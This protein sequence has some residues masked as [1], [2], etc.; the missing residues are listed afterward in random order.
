MNTNQKTLKLVKMALIVA[1]YVAVTGVFAPI[2]FGNIQFRIS[3]ILVLLIFVDGLYLV[4]LTLGCA[5]S[6]FLFSTMGLVDVICGTGATFLALVMIYLTKQFM[7]KRDVKNITL[8]LFASS[9]WA[10]IVNGVIVGAELYYVLQL[11]FWLSVI[12]VAAGEFVVVSIVGVMVFKYIL[13]NERL[14]D[15][16]ILG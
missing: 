16:L 13:S 14:K 6:N 2:S 7:I 12:E 1:I 10:A 15:K 11:P 8:I 4:P 3:E 9:V 5:I